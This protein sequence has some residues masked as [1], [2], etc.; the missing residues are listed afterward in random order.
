MSQPIQ[1][2]RLPFLEETQQR[3]Q[4][5]NEELLAHVPELE[6]VTLILSWSNSDAALPAGIA[7]SRH[8]G[9]TTPGEVITTMRQLGAVLHQLS[10]LQL[11]QQAELEKAWIDTGTKLVENLKGLSKAE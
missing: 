7:G 3:W 6:C 8:G 9:L 4:A 11:Q 1:P 5:F 2:K 10:K